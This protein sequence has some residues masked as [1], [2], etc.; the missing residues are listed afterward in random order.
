M[1]LGQI[2]QEQ[3]Q[4][5]RR[6]LQHLLEEELQLQLFVRQHEGQRLREQLIVLEQ[7]QRQRQTQVREGQTSFERELE[8]KIIIVG[9]SSTTRLHEVTTLSRHF[10]NRYR[11]GVLIVPFVIA[12]VD[13]VLFVLSHG[14]FS[15]GKVDSLWNV[16]LEVGRHYK[17]AK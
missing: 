11:R 9:S 17:R 2:R 12:R 3:H 13:G 1:D 6:Q 7:L 10:R 8:T 5:Q 14:N 15:D 4:E 16:G